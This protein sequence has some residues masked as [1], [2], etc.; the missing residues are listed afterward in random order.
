MK[1]NVLVTLL[2]LIS[3]ISLMFVF[4]ACNGKEIEVTPEKEKEEGITET[5]FFTAAKSLENATKAPKVAVS[6]VSE[7]GDEDNEIY[8]RTSSGRESNPYGIDTTNIPSDSTVTTLS[9]REGV[10]SKTTINGYKLTAQ[11]AN[12]KEY[13]GITDDDVVISNLI[14]TIDIEEIDENDKKEYSLKDIRLEYSMTI[15][16]F[17]FNATITIIPDNA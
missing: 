1:K 11:V 6:L 10:F 13:L 17:K 16:D 9:Y 15:S 2:L 7:I 5:T 12:P 3:I 14:V 4:V 8:A